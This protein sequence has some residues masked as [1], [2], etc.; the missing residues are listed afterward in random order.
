MTQS[1]FLLEEPPAN[2]SQSQGLEKGL[3]TH[4]ETSCLHILPLLNNIAPSG[5]FGKTS[6]A[7]CQATEEKILAPSLGRWGNSGMGS[8]TECLT[9]NTLVFHK[10][11]SACSLSD[12]LETGEVPQRFFLSPTACMGILRRAEKRGKSLPPRLQQALHSVAQEMSE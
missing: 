7:Y 9:L 10:D 5:W 3:M 1:T 12:V 2:H 8:P 4:A 6:P 11:A